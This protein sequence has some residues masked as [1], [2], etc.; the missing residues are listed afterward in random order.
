MPNK[1]IP[2]NIFR[3]Y[4]IRG[5]ADLLVDIS[6]TIGKA[7]GSYFIQQGGKKLVVG[8]DNRKS[9]TSIKEGFV[10]GL[11][12]SGCEVID[13]GLSSS[14][15]LYFTVIEWKM[16]GGINITGSHL[17]PTEN[18]FK[19][20]G[21]EAYPI[22]TMEIEKIRDI[23]LN[24]D[25]AIGTG[26]YSKGNSLDSYLEDIKRPIRLKRPIKIVIDCGNGI[27]GLFAPIVFKI[28]VAR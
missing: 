20:V 12:S 28:Q 4:D 15:L 11:M 10:R 14:P 3:A 16:D 21:K 17:P 8:R 9:S 19:I 26:K 24:N 5:K 18:G 27:T 25:F 23:V 13:I 2:T 22:A 6:E 7:V 1:I